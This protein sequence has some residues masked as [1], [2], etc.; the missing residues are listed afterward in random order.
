MPA[1][2]GFGAGLIPAVRSHIFASRLHVISDLKSSDACAE[3]VPQSKPP[4]ARSF[5][6]SSLPVRNL[7]GD[8]SKKNE[9]FSF[10][11]TR[12]TK[13]SEARADCPATHRRQPGQ[14]PARWQ[15]HNPYT[16]CK[17][18]G[19]PQRGVLQEKNLLSVLEFG[20]PRHLQGMNLRLNIHLSRHCRSVFVLAEVSRQPCFRFKA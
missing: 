18:A 11:S 14:W 5:N 10:G 6:T 1:S 16:H 3:S 9:V 4:M 2:P 17:F 15:G 7:H 20:C 19:N 12:A 8:C 13:H